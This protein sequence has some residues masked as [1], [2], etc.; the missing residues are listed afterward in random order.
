[1]ATVRDAE[2]SYNPQLGD[3]SSA[4]ERLAQSDLATEI[5]LLRAQVSGAGSAIGAL[6]AP[7][8]IIAACAVFATWKHVL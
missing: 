4:L 7:L 1:M 2:D 8:W 5:E 3:I 6:I